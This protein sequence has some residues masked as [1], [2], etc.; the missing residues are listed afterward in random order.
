MINVVRRD[1]VLKVVKRYWRLA[2]F[3]IILPLVGSLDDCEDLL[4]ASDP[5]FAEEIGFSC[6]AQGD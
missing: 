4:C 2:G 3:A 5:G 6:G 1:C